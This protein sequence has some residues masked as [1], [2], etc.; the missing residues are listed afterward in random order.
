MTDSK[1]EFLLLRLN[2]IRNLLFQEK[3]RNIFMTLTVV[4]S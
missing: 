4:R 2:K 1:G 3:C